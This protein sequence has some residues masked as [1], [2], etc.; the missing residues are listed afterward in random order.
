MLQPAL[1]TLAQS[2]EGLRPDKWKTS[3]A[4]REETSSN[5]SSIHRDIETA[6]P[7]LLAG[8]DA[9]PNSV[10]QLLPAYR[11][12]EALYDVLLR[13]GQVAN[14]AAP[15]QQSAAIDHARASLEDARRALGDH[16]NSAALAQEQQVHSLQ[17]ALRAVPPP[18]APVV[19]P[20]PAP[21][22]KRKRVNK[23]VK[24]SAP[25]PA[26]SPVAAPSSH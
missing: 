4:I 19:C 18:A 7:Q 13:V 11:N 14:L 10:S 21:V 15:N 24:K 26:S 2:L 9:A 17:T 23:P 3:D 12:I 25:S 16:L 22:K 6:L 8:A 20:T 1:N 5:I